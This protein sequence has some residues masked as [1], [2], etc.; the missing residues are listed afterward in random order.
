M[1]VYRYAKSNIALCLFICQR[2]ISCRFS[3][4]V[5]SSSRVAMVMMVVVTSNTIEIDQIQI[6]PMHKPTSHEA[7]DIPLPQAP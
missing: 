4:D 3:A 7:N 2:L 5:D 6:L 1:E